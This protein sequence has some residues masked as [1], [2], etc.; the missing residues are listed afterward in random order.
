MLRDHT[1]DEETLEV[2]L[3]APDD[4]EDADTPEDAP[5]P[6]QDGTEEPQ[7]G[8]EEP[9]NDQEPTEDVN[10]PQ[11]GEETFPREYVEKLRTEAADARIKAKRAEDYARRL[12]HA[13]VGATGRLADPTD[14][15]FDEANVMD[16]EQLNAA[17]DSLL[18]T[19]P[20]LASR[21]PRGNIGQG[22]VSTGDGTVSLAGLLRS[23]AS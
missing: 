17:I 16:E 5:E 18:E 11:E 15:P 10:E 6:P 20:H 4:A 23:R 12:Q 2:P 22:P 1:D 19:K 14:L 3:N 8:A 9:Q 7:D 13:L 21:R